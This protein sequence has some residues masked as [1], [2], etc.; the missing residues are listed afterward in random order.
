MKFP[1]IEL[2]DR[3]CIAQLKHEKTAANPEEIAFYKEQLSLYKIDSI[4]IELSDLFEIHKKIWDLESEL[5][6]GKEY[7]LSL[8]EIGRRAIAIRDWN[9][10]RVSLK[11]I[12][13]EKLGCSVREVKINHAS[14]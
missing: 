11:N 3:F 8:E 5:K 2:V 12:M 6:S 1:I 10:K 14:Q 7:L 13:A 9:N 4:S